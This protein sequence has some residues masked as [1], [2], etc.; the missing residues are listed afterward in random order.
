MALAA[1]HRLAYFDTGA[2]NRLT[3]T[4]Q[5][6]TANLEASAV[7]TASIADDAVT[8]AKAAN[9][10]QSTIKG[11]AAG[12]GTGDPT[13]L[14][15]LQVS[16]L[17]GNDIVILGTAAMRV[18][19]G[20]PAEST[21]H[22]NLTHCW[23]HD[24]ASGEAVGGYLR[25]PGWATM[26]MQVMWCPSD[27]GAGDVMWEVGRVT[28]ADGAMPSGANTTFTSTAPGV[29]NQTVI[30]AASATVSVPSGSLVAIR[31]N[32]R[33]GDAADTYGSDAKSMAV[34]FTRVT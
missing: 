9:M 8:N 18:L 1:N 14:T 32:R 11:R 17:L 31:L 26:T 16:Q 13:D 3:P 5:I 27:T 20:S 23:L 19:S 7:A 24:A 15:P 21:T 10:A 29:A 2:G 12:A 4:A 34:I 25:F 22:N 30:T 28:L 6:A 33:A